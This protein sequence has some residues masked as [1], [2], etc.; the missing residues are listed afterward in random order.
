MSQCRGRE[1]P[2]TPTH[3]SRIASGWCRRWSRS[4]CLSFGRNLA[5]HGATG[6]QRAPAFL[7]LALAVRSVRAP[8]AALATVLGV[9]THLCLARAPLV[10]CC[11]SGST[12]LM[13]I[14]LI[15]ECADGDDNGDP[16]GSQQLHVTTR[17]GRH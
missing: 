5:T 2:G 4:R 16:N 1:G 13:C 9:A 11:K 3:T 6:I 7:A 15:R 14:S 8:H 10:A 17:S 12:V